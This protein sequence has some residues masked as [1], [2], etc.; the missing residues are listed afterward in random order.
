MLLVITIYMI[1]IANMIEKKR[2][3]TVKSNTPPY[4][5]EKKETRKS[6]LMSKHRNI[7]FMPDLAD[8]CPIPSP[9]LLESQLQPKEKQNHIQMQ[10]P[11]T[12][13]AELLP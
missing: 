12:H 6:T 9:T 13:K 7:L 5:L 10:Q 4:R 11:P 2:T 1:E 8:V 3:V